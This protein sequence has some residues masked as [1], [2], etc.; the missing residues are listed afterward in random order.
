MLDRGSFEIMLDKVEK[1]YLEDFVTLCYGRLEKGKAIHESDYVELDLY[2]QIIEE[3]ADVANYAFLEYI[4]VRKL[5][6]MKENLLKD[7]P[8]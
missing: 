4:K 7:G 2:Q 8:L 5:K 3:L 6:D 1:K